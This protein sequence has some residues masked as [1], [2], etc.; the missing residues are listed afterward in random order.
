MP[1]LSIKRAYEPRAST[2]GRRILV[3]RLWPRGV[4]KHDL[5]DALWVRDVAPSA[6]L[7]KWFGHKAERWDEF[8]K[9]YLAEL[10][11]N[12]AVDTVREAMRSG[13]VTLVY[14]A[15]DEAHNQAVVLADYL[16]K[17]REP[18]PRQKDAADEH[19]VRRR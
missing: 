15:K 1:A 11:A 10:R 6:Q 2:D 9:R 7:R 8:R 19:R 17:G 12:P 18:A 4:A 5:E 13:P 14:G 3:D 16:T